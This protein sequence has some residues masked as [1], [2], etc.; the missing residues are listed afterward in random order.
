MKKVV[1]GILLFLIC[2]CAYYLYK[3]LK[4]IV[5][6][7]TGNYSLCLQPFDDLP[8]G[9]AMRIYNK[10]KM[11]IPDLRIASSLPLPANAWI[12]TRGRY[13]ADTIIYWLRQRSADTI[14]YI[15]ITSKDI[16][17]T[18]G[19]V[20]DWGIMGLGFQPGNGCVVSTFRLNKT[21]ED[22]QLYKLCLHELG[23]N[24]GLPHCP[25]K[26][27]YMRDAEGGN[28]KD[29]ENGFCQSCAKVLEH[30]GLH[31]VPVDK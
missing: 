8:P 9:Q 29:D 22:E 25:Q 26:Y 30:R 17:T 15:G 2:L 20:A 31:F 18:K 24:M 21:K 23:H 11:D 4:Q 16:S 19:K 28:H 7:Y 14:L 1:W 12:K 10:I 3:P 5:N 6:I 27:C 13:K